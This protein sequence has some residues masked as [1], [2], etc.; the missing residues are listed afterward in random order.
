MVL[1]LSA[2]TVHAT[3][4]SIDNKAIP[5]KTENKLSSEEISRINKRVEEIS[6]I[7]RSKLTSKEKH[8]LRKELRKIKA[9]A[10]KNPEV[11]YISSGTLILILILVILLV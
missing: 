10:Q 3:K 4:S 6:K 2:S 11:I 7:D 1:S 9:T 5:V 8:Q